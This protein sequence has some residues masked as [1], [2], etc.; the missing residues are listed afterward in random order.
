MSDPQV[1]GRAFDTEFFGQPFD[2]PYIA[3]RPRMRW[4]LRLPPLRLSEIEL[5]PITDPPDIPRPIMIELNLRYGAGLPGAVNRVILLWQ[6]VQGSGVPAIAADHYMAGELTTAQMQAIVSSDAAGGDWSKRAIFH[7]WPDFTMEPQIDVSCTTIK[8][9]PAQRSFGAFGDGIVWAV[10]D[11]GVQADHPHFLG[12]DTLTDPLVYGLH[13]DFTQESNDPGLA[14]TDKTGHGSHV[15][16]IIAGGLERWKPKD[17]KRNVIAVEKRFNSAALSGRDAILEPRYADP[18]LLAGVAPLAKL[19]SLKVGG[20]TD[21]KVR[22]ERALKALAYIREVN[23]NSGRVIHGVNLSLGY[24]FDPEWSGCGQSPLCIAV[25]NLVRSGVV[26]VVASGNT[27]YVTLNPA[28]SRDV[29]RFSAGL[30][31]NDPGN[32]ERA[33]TVGSTHRTSPHTSGISYFSSRGPTGDG[34]PK[35]DLVA[36]GEHIMSV[37]AGDKLSDVAKAYRDD[38]GEAAVYIDDSGTSMAAPHVSGAI[39]AFLS[40]QRELIGQPEEIKRIFMATATSLQRDRSCQG[41]GLVDLM[42]ALQAQ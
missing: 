3:M 36:P 21:V 33:I 11:S 40:I 31:I 16:G 25:D 29:R 6:M 5:P 32:A 27:G 10:I 26:V 30:T 4:P 23:G 15:A 19:V 39:A 9:L 14:L 28:Y 2:A 35:P 34:R 17:G 22:T 41:A 12:Y 18:K 13:R 38:L 20:S 1:I 7:M 42:R 8:A 37:A 24:P